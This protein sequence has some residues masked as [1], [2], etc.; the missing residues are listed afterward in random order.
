MVV[1]GDSTAHVHS[2]LCGGQLTNTER[3]SYIPVINTSFSNPSFVHSIDCMKY[4]DT[5]TD[6]TGFHGTN[7]LAILSQYI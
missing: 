3:T 1:I 6:C 4:S 2:D 7:K 5:F